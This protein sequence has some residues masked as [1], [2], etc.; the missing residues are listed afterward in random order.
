M[1]SQ[2]RLHPATLA[3]VKQKLPA[4][5]DAEVSLATVEGL[6]VHQLRSFLKVMGLSTDGDKARLVR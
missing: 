4:M 5:A 3:P 1:G 2:R 6:R